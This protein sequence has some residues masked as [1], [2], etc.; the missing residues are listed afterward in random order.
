M[1]NKINVTDE[2]LLNYLDGSLHSSEREAVEQFVATDQRV[3]TRLK[4]LQVIHNHFVAVALEEPS[5][6]FTANVMARLQAPFASGFSVRNSILLLIGVLT[7]VGIAA[8]LLASG[9][10]DATATINLNDMGFGKYINRELPAVSFNGKLIVNLIMIANIALA[11]V[12][13]DRAVLKPWF[14]R[15]RNIFLI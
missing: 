7:A 12:V 5:K 8:F 3:Q 9:V 11:F 10:F 14:E 13:L 4:E 6:N 1:E 2:Q 15:R